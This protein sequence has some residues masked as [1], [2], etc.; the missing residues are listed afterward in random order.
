MRAVMSP[1]FEKVGVWS[2]RGLRVAGK[3]S[4]HSKLHLVC[5]LARAGRHA[6]SKL[7]S[8]SHSKTSANES[9]S[10]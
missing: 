2:C 3:I 1:L 5:S 7:A 6:L 10:L 8:P 9:K 4:A